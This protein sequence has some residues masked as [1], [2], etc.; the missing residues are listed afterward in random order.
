[1]SHPESQ[2][3]ACM[4]GPADYEARLAWIADLARDA[5]RGH[6]RDDLDL[7]LVYAADAAQ[8]VRE[9]VEKER[10]C[11]AFLVF[12]LDEEPGEIR[13]TIRAPESARDIAD[14]LFGAFLPS[15]EPAAGRGC[16]CVPNLENGLLG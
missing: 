15:A 3:I 10:E 1:M 4:L 8:R 9:M 5:L 2:P 7:E 11:C 12:D 14:R 16:C 13:L 6:R